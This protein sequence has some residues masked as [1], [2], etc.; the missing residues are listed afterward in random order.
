MLSLRPVALCHNPTHAPQQSTIKKR[1]DSIKIE[2]TETSRRDHREM[3]SRACRK[4]Q[5]R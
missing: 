5:L 3:P 1:L 2:S 4:T